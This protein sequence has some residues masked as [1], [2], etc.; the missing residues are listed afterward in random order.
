MKGP[1][2]S[3]FRQCPALAAEDDAPLPG[4]PHL[5][6][7]RLEPVPSPSELLIEPLS[8]GTAVLPLTPPAANGTAGHAGTPVL[9]APAQRA[10]EP[11]AGSTEE[12]TAIP[13]T[14]FGVRSK[15]RP[16]RAALGRA[17]PLCASSA[18]KIIQS[19]FSRQLHGQRSTKQ[20]R[21]QKSPSLQRFVPLTPAGER[22]SQGGG[23]PGAWAHAGPVGTCCGWPCLGQRRVTVV[24]HPT[25]HLSPRQHHEQPD[26]LVKLPCHGSRDGNLHPWAGDASC[27]A[28]LVSRRI[29]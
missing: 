29:R 21:R 13:A 6:G 1:G 20:K 27:P 3:Q 4:T 15:T 7:R 24:L 11:R 12:V 2:G 18:I 19:G 25:C 5:Q 23:V 10:S 22:G 17:F 26:R 28:A 9:P 8:S 14:A 16:G